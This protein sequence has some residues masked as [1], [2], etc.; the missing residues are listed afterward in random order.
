M[1]STQGQIPAE[2]SKLL[3]EKIVTFARKHGIDI[4]ND[5]ELMKIFKNVDL[6]K[7]MPEEMI[8][9]VS[10]LIFYIYQLRNEWK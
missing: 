10:E 9:L 6:N 3:P 2:E 1:D 5:P 7:K 8:T 4:E